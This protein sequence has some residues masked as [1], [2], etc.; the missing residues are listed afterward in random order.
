MAV[1]AA[2]ALKAASDSGRVALHRGPLS[3][4][5]RRCQAEARRRKCD[6]NIPWDRNDNIP[7]HT[8]KDRKDFK[9]NCGFM[10]R[11]EGLEPPRCYP[12]PP[13]GSA[14]TNSATSAKEKPEP[15]EERHRINGARVSNRCR[16]DKGRPALKY[17]SVDGFRAARRAIGTSGSAI[18]ATYA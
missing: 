12:L 6:G 5:F 16:G 7:G 11:S 18:A 15:E 8:R 13:Q 1:R 10:V 3:R 2:F 9:L 4:R 14:S 17:R